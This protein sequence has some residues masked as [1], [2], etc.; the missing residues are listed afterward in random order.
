M[1][2]PVNYSIKQFAEDMWYY[3]GSMLSFY[4]AMDTAD[5]RNQALPLILQVLRSFLALIQVSNSIISTQANANVSD[6]YSG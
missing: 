3:A 2:L 6:R 1:L 5:A 4:P